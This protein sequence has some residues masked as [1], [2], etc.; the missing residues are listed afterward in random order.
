MEI[1]ATTSSCVFGILSLVLR[2]FGISEAVFEVT[3]KG[4]SNN[5][6][7][8]GNVGKFVFNESP[9]FIIGTAMVLLQLMALGSKLLAGI[10]QPPSSSDGRRGSGIGEILGCVWV[11]MT[12]SPFLRGLFAKGKYG[13][14]FPTICKSASLILLF[15]PFYKWL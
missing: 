3:P 11:L 5:N 12:L 7:D 1:I 9:L 8:D 2:L 14:P 13:I 15:V 6:V 10:L 4:Q